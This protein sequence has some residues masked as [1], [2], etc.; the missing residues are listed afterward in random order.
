MLIII[1]EF[2]YL[3]HILFSVFI[4]WVKIWEWKKIGLI[5]NCGHIMK[6]TFQNNV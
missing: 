1:D 6:T 5:Y 2:E 3:F 4:P